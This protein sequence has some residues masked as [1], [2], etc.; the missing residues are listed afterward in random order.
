MPVFEAQVWKIDE[1]KNYRLDLYK[2]L[3][4]W[5]MQPFI[6]SHL[7]EAIVYLKNNKFNLCFM[8]IE[9][10]NGGDIS[11]IKEIENVLT[12][13]VMF[14][15]NKQ[16]SDDKKIKYTLEK[17][18]IKAELLKLCLNLFGDRNIKKKKKSTDE[19]KIYNN[20]SILISDDNK[21]NQQI[22]ANMLNKLGY[23]N[24]DISNDGEETIRK[25]I[26]KKINY[27]LHL[28]DIH[29]PKIDGYKIVKT[30]KKELKGDVY[31]VAMVNENKKEDKKIKKSE[32][33][34]YITKPINLNELRAILKV[35]SRHIIKEI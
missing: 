8:D 18:I 11:I 9:I 31:I 7:D 25:T 26:K 10:W 29:L 15:K 5:E 34:A 33:D 14:D 16:E 21:F 22:V 4:D 20:F 30:L 28:V 6:C 17:P 19:I 32:F 2:I 24:I 3:S 12:I 35:I 13:I 23:K 27:D 1:D